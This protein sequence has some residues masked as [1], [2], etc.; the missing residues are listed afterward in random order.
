M[1][2]SRWAGGYSTHF[3]LGGRRGSSCV[4]GFIKCAGGKRF[5]GLHGSTVFHRGHGAG[6]RIGWSHWL[7]MAICFIGWWRLAASSADDRACRSVALSTGMTCFL[8]SDT[9]GRGYAFAIC[10]RGTQRFGGTEESPPLPVFNDN[11]VCLVISLS[12]LFET[13][14]RFGL[15]AMLPPYVFSLRRLRAVS[16]PFF[17]LRLD[18]QIRRGRGCA[19]SILTRGTQRSGWLQSN[20]LGLR[21]ST[22]WASATLNHCAFSLKHW[23]DSLLATLPH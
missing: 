5:S 22:T 20:H 3:P 17:D 19:F 2:T 1:S 14:A 23:R 16:R 11:G 4:H 8:L 21:C 9:E 6:H 12:L 7:L 13:L 18:F 15:L 10:T